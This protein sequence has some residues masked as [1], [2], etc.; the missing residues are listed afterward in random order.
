MEINEIKN[1]LFS[2]LCN[3]SYEIS[4]DEHLIIIKTPLR[5]D[6]GDNVVVFITPQEDKFLIHDNGEAATRL[7]FEGVDIDSQ[8]IQSWLKHIQ[9][10]YQIEWDDKRDKLWCKAHSQS[11]IDRIIC[12]A[13]VSVQMQTL[14]EV[15]LKSEEQME[16]IKKKLKLENILSQLLEEILSEKLEEI[17]SGKSLFDNSKLTQQRTTTNIV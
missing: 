12:M 6:D 9:A 8:L 7:M 13:Q 4:Q 3:K 16:Q 5:Y 10:V 14:A 17:S 2:E 1:M 11:L 15:V